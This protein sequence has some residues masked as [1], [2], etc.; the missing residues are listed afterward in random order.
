[1]KKIMLLVMAAVLSA[2]II[3]T[4]YAQEDPKCKK[5]C[6]KKCDDKCEK[7]C[8][9]EECTKKCDDKKAGSKETAKA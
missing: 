1:M 5:E 9:K 2:G 8:S 4:S 7:K 6:C 3:S